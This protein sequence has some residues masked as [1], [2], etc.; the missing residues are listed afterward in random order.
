MSGELTRFIHASDFHLEQPLY[1]LASIPDHLRDL[2]LDA[3]Y[4]AATRVFD[5]A[6]LEHVDFVVLSGDL[7]DPLHAGPRGLAFLL[8]QFQRLRERGIQVFWAGG[9]IDSPEA[10][11]ATV[12]LP[13]NVHLFG[14]G[15]LEDRVVE[16]DGESCAAVVGISWSDRLRVHP[17]EF[18]GDASERFKIAVVHGEFDPAALVRQNIQY[19]ALGGEHQRRTLYSTPYAAH[20]PGSPQGRCGEETGPHG[21]TLVSVD[22]DG[23]TRMQAI[24]TDVLRWHE[25][26]IVVSES[27][28]KNDLERVLRDRMQALAAEVG[29][30]ALLIRL[31]LEASGRLAGGLRHS[32]MADEFAAELRTEYGHR[33]HPAWIVAIDVE[34]PSTLPVEWYEEDSILGDFLRSV[35]AHEQGKAEPLRL[36]SYLSDEQAA[37]PFGRALEIADPAARA[38]LMRHAAVLG[39]DMLRGELANED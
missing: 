38:R 29:D 19:W 2:A 10:W 31:R 16:R 39:I 13:A 37:G 1:G 32:G 12:P 22:P 15:R 8:E 24:P 3:P 7:L 34:P 6:I 33:R 18:R 36:S 4:L 20:Y 9:R 14:S 35:R 25:E 5:S 26:R 30:R 27:M 28:T 17:S 23:K 21:C 11:P